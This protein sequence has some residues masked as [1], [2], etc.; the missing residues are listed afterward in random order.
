LL[1]IKIILPKK[2]NYMLVK[3]IKDVISPFCTINDET[4]RQLADFVTLKTLK[5]NSFLEKEGETVKSEFIV[6][7]GVVRAFVIN[8]KRDIS[9]WSVTVGS[10]SNSY[11]AIFA[12]TLILSTA[13][14]MNIYI[15]TCQ[16]TVK[17]QHGTE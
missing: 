6:L 2:V 13:R 11:S 16:V 17:K 1:K 3:I 10:D 5:I 7:E 9:C 8:H 15:L 14:R 12:S 4:A